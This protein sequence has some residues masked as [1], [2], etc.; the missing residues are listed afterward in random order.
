MTRNL[1]EGRKSIGSLGKTLVHIIGCG[2]FLVDQSRFARLWISADLPLSCRAQALPRP[3][4]PPEDQFITPT[5][6]EQFLVKKI[7][8]LVTKVA[9]SFESSNIRRAAGVLIAETHVND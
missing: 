3:V 1:A 5:R 4:Q 6:R 2:G 8:P 9:I 7:A